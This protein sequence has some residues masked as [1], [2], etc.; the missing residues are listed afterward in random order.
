MPRKLNPELFNHRTRRLANGCL[1]WI[2][3][4]AGRYGLWGRRQYAH[5]EAWERAYGKIPPGLCVCHICDIPLCV[6]PTHLWIGTQKENLRDKDLKGHRRLFFFKK[7][8]D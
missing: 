6:E 2:G 5:R 8:R 3:P 4:T 7:R 1:I